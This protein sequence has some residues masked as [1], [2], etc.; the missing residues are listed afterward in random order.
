MLDEALRLFDHHLGDLHV[1]L[2]RLVEGG[3]DHFALDGSLH[4]GNFFRPLVDQQDDQEHLG[5]VRRDRLRD[6][7]Q[8]HRLAGPRR[9][10]D[11]AALA[12]ADRR[13]Q[14]HDPR[15]EVLPGCFE[16]QSLL[17]VERREV[18]EKQ[19]VARLLGRFEVDRFDL[20]EREVA[21][22]FFRRTNLA[23]HR[24]AGLQI[25]FADL[26][27]RHVNVVG[28]WQVVVVRRAEK[29]EAVGQHFEHALREDEAALFG[30]RLQDLKDQLLLAHTG[31]ASDIHILRDLCELLNA[32]VLQIGDVEPFAWAPWRP[33]FWRLG[34]RLGRRRGG[35][36][37]GGSIRGP[38]GR[39]ALVVTWHERS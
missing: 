22:A 33:A 9:R 6:V 1:A 23:R 4:V 21:L 28:A 14:I 10:D 7:L 16:L 27:W 17:R 5:M 15:R 25:E 32:H 34:G 38:R 35:V 26:G 24:V 20:D 18:F 11:Q 30:L 31:G 19:L 29:A 2:R 37:R 36:G 13:H 8:Q 3:R 39:I 12:L